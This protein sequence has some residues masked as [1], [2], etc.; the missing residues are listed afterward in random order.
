MARRLGDDVIPGE[1]TSYDD[2]LAERSWSGRK[3]YELVIRNLEVSHPGAIES[4]V[5]HPLDLVRQR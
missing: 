5:K 1:S 2:G 3:P 4:A